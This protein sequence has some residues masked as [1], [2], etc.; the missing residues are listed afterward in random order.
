MLH[1]NDSYLAQVHLKLTTLG[2]SA[3][4][5][6]KAISDVHKIF[7]LRLF[8]TLESSLTEEEKILFK[9]VPLE[10]LLS[11]LQGYYET[12]GAIPLVEGERILNEIWESYFETM[13]KIHS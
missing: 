1:I 13:G 3:G 11:F 2:F 8:A 9:E 10:N 12:H 7:A 4:D 5:A 6:E